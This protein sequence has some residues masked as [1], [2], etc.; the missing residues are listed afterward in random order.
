MRRAL[1][2]AVAATGIPVAFEWI[3]VRQVSAHGFG[4]R[5]DLPLPLSL[6]VLAGGATVALS[7]VI[8]VP[9][10]GESCARVVPA[11]QSVGHPRR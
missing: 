1:F 5:Y 11:T 4:E 2:L 9:P 8:V 6:F 10:E 3:A 7:F